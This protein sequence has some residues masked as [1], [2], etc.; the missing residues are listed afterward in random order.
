GPANELRLSFQRNGQRNRGL[1]PSLP[2]QMAARYPN[3]QANQKQE[4]IFNVSNDGQWHTY[5]INT[6]GNPEWKDVIQQYT[7]GYNGGDTIPFPD[8]WEIQYI[9]VKNPD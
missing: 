2:N 1:D 9:G 3:G 6:T 8:T 7:L 5:Q 4:F